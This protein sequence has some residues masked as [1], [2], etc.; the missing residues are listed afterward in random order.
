M[1]VAMRDNKQIGLGGRWLLIAIGA[2]MSTGLFGSSLFAHAVGLVGVAL[3]AAAIGLVE[4]AMA[5]WYRWRDP[6][7]RS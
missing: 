3:V 1:V 5:L 4:L 7:I 2:V 6:A